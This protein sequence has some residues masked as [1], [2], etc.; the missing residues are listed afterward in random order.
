MLYSRVWH[1]GV[2][3]DGQFQLTVTKELTEALKERL[4]RHG[5]TRPF[6]LD[7]DAARQDKM[8]TWI[9]YLGYEY[10]WYDYYAGIAKESPE[11]ARQ[12]LEEAR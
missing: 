11:T 3:V 1:R 8:T 10:W 9:E 12:C 5:F 7:E 2:T 4:A 6:Q